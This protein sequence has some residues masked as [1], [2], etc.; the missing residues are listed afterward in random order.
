MKTPCDEVTEFLTAAD[1]RA[2]LKPPSGVLAHLERCGPCRRLWEFL[3]GDDDCPEEDRE[4]DALASIRA[5]VGGSLSPVRPLPSRAAL[6]A[7]FLGIFAAGVAASTAMAGA[8]GAASSM[9]PLRLYGFLFALALAAAFSA[10]LLSGLMMPGSCRALSRAGVAMAGFL[11]ALVA[12]AAL[13]FPWEGLADWSSG[14][15]T[16]FEQGLLTGLP[17]AAVAALVLRRGAVLSP[18]L[19]GAAAGLLGGLAGAT[20]L[21]LAC[22]MHGAVHVTTGHLS[23]PLAMSAAGYFIGRAAAAISIRRAASLQVAR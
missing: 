6:V 10:F 17:M 12:A 21:H 11:V 1:A 5:T 4:A 18:G 14:A 7:A 16:C 15:R 13:I 8:N 20:M 22:P 23:A 3:V 9:G 2:R 19:A